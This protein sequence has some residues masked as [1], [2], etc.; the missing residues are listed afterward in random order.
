MAREILIK[1]N[2][3]VGIVLAKM[4]SGKLFVYANSGFGKSWLLRRLIEQLFGK[5]QIIVIDTEGEFSTLREKYDF[6]L[7][8]RGLDIEP[9][10]KTAAL[11][12]HR[13]LASKVSAVI[14]IYELDP[15]DREKFVK[16]F[17]AALT[18]APKNLWHPAAIIYDEAQ[19]YAPEKPLSGEQFACAAEIVKFA[20]KG[21]KRGF[22][23]IFATQRIADISKSVIATCTNKLIGQASHDTDMKR[24]AAE[25]GFN[26]KEEVRQM[27]D[28]D[29]GEFYAFGP[30]ISKEIQRL[31]I[32][33]I[34]TTH[35]DSSKIGGRIG[36]MKVAPPSAKV[37][38]ALKAL[39][40][41]PQAVTEEANTIA[42]YKKQIRELEEKVRSAGKPVM[43][44]AAIDRAVQNAIQQTEIRIRKES[45]ET[46]AK[47]RYALTN[48]STT[49]KKIAELTSRPDVLELTKIDVKSPPIPITRIKPDVIPVQP[50]PAN[51]TS[52]EPADPSAISG[53]EQKVLN[54]IAWM[55]SIGVD[56]PEKSAVAFVAGY[57]PSASGYQNACGALR[58]KGLATYPASGTI[59]LTDAGRAAAEVPEGIRSNAELQEKILA[60]LSG[61][62]HSILKA[63]IEIYPQEIHKE[64]LAIK[65]DKSWMASGFQ[66]ACGRLRSLGLVRYPGPNMIEAEKILFP[67]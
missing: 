62:E 30:A 34:Q 48:A 42:G 43:D 39:A 49:L 10:P 8:G 55:N 1:L 54:A 60:K 26:T 64:Q 67:L 18:N 52:S 66:N 7:I 23:P 35:P 14:D 51:R 13:L 12:C 57:S 2:D 24:A 4:I 22:M 38:A 20:K 11:M 6:L 41:L 9:D 32:G 33:P 61:Q 44:P 56:P 25:L 36:K 59:E 29:P 37:R 31:K 46:I 27:R 17:T 28:L 47:M 5:I 65:I 53:P 19:D 40:D 45:E 16:N 15:V 3:K 63:L 50:A 21:R 58:T